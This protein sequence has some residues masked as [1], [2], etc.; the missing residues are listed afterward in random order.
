[1]PLINRVWPRWPRVALLYGRAANTGYPAVTDTRERNVE[2]LEKEMYE[3]WGARFWGLS[4]EINLNRFAK[5]ADPSLFLPY[6]LVN[7]ANLKTQHHDIYIDIKW[8]YII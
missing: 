7:D 8:Y 2:M 1:M 6:P 4:W 5:V 3:I